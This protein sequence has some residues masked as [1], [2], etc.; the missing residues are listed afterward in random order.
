M[1][2]YLQLI[3]DLRAGNIDSFDISRDEYFQFREVWLQQEDK[4]FF[5]GFAKLGGNIIYKYDTTVV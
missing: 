4:K 1:R 3:T 5:R 2:D